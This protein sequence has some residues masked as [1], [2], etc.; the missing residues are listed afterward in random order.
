VTGVGTD[1]DRE[2]RDLV[3]VTFSGAIVATATPTGGN[4]DVVIVTAI[5]NTIGIGVVAANGK[6]SHS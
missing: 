1:A 4:A 6:V 2:G 5:G 3:L